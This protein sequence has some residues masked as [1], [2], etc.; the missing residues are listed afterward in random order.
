MCMMT[1]SDV[2]NS[3]S[4]MSYANW[5]VPAVVQL[6]PAGA[7]KVLN[8]AQRASVTYHDSLV[9]S[10]PRSTS[11]DS[12][13]IASVTSGDVTLEARKADSSSVT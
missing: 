5:H 7:E 9:V 8:L 1:A 13:D 2:W 3:R 12:W 4:R 6:D 10:G 11:R